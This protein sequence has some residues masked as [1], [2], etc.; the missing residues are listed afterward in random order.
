VKINS[1]EEVQLGLKGAAFM[2]GVIKL[3]EVVQMRMERGSDSSA[4]N[5]ESLGEKCHRRVIE[6]RF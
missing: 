2:N 3:S 5:M 4:R 1:A 6:C